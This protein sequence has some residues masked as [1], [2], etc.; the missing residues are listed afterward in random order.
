MAM[1]KMEELSQK[2][3]PFF[4]AVGYSK[5]HLAYLAPE[6]YWDLYDDNDI[7]Y[8]QIDQLPEDFPDISYYDSFWIRNEFNRT[9][10]E[11]MFS[12]EVQKDLIHGYYACVSFIDNQVGQLVEKLKELDLDD[13]TIIV[14]MSDHG[15]QLY[16]HGIWGKHT[17]FEQANNAPLIIKYPN[18]EKNKRVNSLVEY[19]DVYP[20]LCDLAGFEIPDQCQGESLKSIMDGTETKSENDYAYSVYNGY[21][22]KSV[23]NYRY[24]YVET[25]DKKGKIIAQQ[26]YDYK[27]DPFEKRNV[28]KEEPKVLR[29]MKQL[30]DKADQRA[31]S[32]AL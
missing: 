9:P 3:Q 32:Q 19:V 13:N 5:P 17:L 23:R 30:L 18:S 25:L 6:K 31:T 14:L 22:N 20:T 21:S 16:D 11:G 26:L 29:K 4:I 15:Y 1:D 10:K 12:K 7:E 24:R 27:K 2:Q 8:P 28:A